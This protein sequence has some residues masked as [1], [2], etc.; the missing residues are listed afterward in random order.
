MGF[1]DYDADIEQAEFERLGSASAAARARGECPHG[2]RQGYTAKHRP[3]LR[4]GQEQ[5]LDCGK[6][7]TPDVLDAERSEAL[8]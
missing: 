1:F 3:D 5:C 4:P 7:A 6:I 2:S 8:G